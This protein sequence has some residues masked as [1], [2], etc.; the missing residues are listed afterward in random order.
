MFVF[1]AA[2]LIGSSACA[3]QWVRRT[4]LCDQHLRDRDRDAVLRRPQS[5]ARCCCS[6]GSLSLCGKF[7]ERESSGIRCAV[8]SARADQSDEC[9]RG[10]TQV[11]AVALV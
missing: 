2:Q 7:D 11:C 8:A 4:A 3:T 5:L 6:D 10:W 1:P 9:A